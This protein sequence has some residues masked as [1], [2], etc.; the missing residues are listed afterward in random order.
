MNISGKTTAYTTPHSYSFSAA[1]INK[2][3]NFNP[4]SGE[5]SNSKNNLK[6]NVNHRSSSKS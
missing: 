3:Q 5:F 2:R 4:S 6:S 1:A